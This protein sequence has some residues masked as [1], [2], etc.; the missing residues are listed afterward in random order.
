MFQK[1]ITSTPYLSW[2]F[3]RV[4]FERSSCHSCNAAAMLLAN[5]KLNRNSPDIL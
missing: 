3:C 5:I 1:Y 2:P 4:H